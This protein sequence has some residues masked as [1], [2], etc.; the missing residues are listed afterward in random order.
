MQI[1]LKT[2]RQ[3]ILIGT[4]V[5]DLFFQ[6][7]FLWYAFYYLFKNTF[8][9]PGIFYFRLFSKS[10]LLKG[11]QIKNYKTAKIHKLYYKF[12]QTP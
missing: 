2:L 3:I 12:D 1:I 6:I 9:F 7:A 5:A 8:A 4:E 11:V 10:F